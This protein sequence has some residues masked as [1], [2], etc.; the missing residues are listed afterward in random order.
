M[1][2]SLPTFASSGRW[3]QGRIS[4]MGWT[5]WRTS[6]TESGRGS[7]VLC[8]AVLC[9]TA[10]RWVLLC[11]VEV[12]VE[13]EVTKAAQVRVRTGSGHSVGRQWEDGCSAR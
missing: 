9:C 10:G 1:E 12:E 8:C 7:G 11:E 3:F 6:G 2:T 13:V 4:M 5:R